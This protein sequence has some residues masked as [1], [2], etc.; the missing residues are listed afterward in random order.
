MMVWEWL[1]DDERSVISVRICS[2]VDQGVSLMRCWDASDTGDG[3]GKFS[4]S[5]NKS[6]TGASRAVDR[7]VYGYGRTPYD[8]Y[9][10]SGRTVY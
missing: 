8:K 6:C 9:T 4:K 5:R 1:S 10:A 2:L 3:F 7:A